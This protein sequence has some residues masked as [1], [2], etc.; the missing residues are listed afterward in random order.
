MSRTE[1]G[2]FV[3]DILLPAGGN[4]LMQL[5]DDP[6]EV[7]CEAEESSGMRTASGD[8]LPN[9]RRFNI[10]LRVLPAELYFLKVEGLEVG[11]EYIPN[12]P[13]CVVPPTGLISWWAADDNFDDRVSAFHRMPNDV[14][15]FAPGLPGSVFSFEGKGSV[16]VDPQ[17]EL[18]PSALTIAAWINPFSYKSNRVLEKGGWRVDGSYGLKFNP[19]GTKGIRFVVWNELAQVIDSDSTVPLCVRTHIAGVFDGSEMCLFVNGLEQNGSQRANMTDNDIPLTIGRASAAEDLFFLGLIDEIQ[20]YDR[21]LEPP[22][23]PAMFQTGN[24]GLCRDCPSDRPRLSILRTGNLL[25]TIWPLCPGWKLEETVTVG[26]TAIR[27]RI[28]PPYLTEA[29]QHR[30]TLQGTT[31]CRFYRLRKP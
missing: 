8:A 12:A 2:P 30:V 4:L 23:I 22:E 25:D 9:S 21:G 28:T 13:P 18:P 20:L 19:F 7:I 26:R 17:P 24:A 6:G 10:T 14:A 29:T 27:H 5:L 11:I 31:D 1:P 16:R 3:L 15:G